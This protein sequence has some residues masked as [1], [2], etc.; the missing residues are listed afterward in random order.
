MQDKTKIFNTAFNLQMTGKAKEALK[1]YLKL[2]KDLEK[3]FLN[4]IKDKI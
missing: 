3:I 2:I 4:L 1:H